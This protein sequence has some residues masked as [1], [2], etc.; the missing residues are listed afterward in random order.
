MLPGIHCDQASW[1][2]RRQSPLMAVAVG[3][4]TFSEKRLY[5][6]VATEQILKNDATLMTS[7]RTHRLTT[8]PAQDKLLAS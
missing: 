6:Q 2:D 4:L 5:I 7:L 1:G 8:N 3:S